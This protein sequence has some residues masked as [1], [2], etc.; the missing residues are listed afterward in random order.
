MKKILITGAAA[1]LL[2]VTATAAFATGGSV[3]PKMDGVTLSVNSQATSG[4][5]TITGQV[6]DSTVGTGNAT[7]LVTVKNIVK[8]DCGCKLPVT[9]KVDS[10]AKTGSIDIRGSGGVTGDSLVLTG[11]ATSAVD[12]LNV[13]TTVVQHV[14]HPGGPM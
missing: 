14:N 6:K 11:N 10:T 12:A 1:G 2:L 13:V 3:M 5:I 9:L 7:S 4:Q 8:G